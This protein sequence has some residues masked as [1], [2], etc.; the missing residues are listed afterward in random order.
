MKTITEGN[1]T[2]FDFENPTQK[3]RDWLKNNFNIQKEKIEHINEYLFL[4][5]RAPIFRQEKKT[6]QSVGLDIFINENRLITVHNEAIE[7]LKNFF[8]KCEKNP[9]LKSKYFGQTTGHL[10]YWISEEILDFAERQLVHI[11]KN[12]NRVEDNMF[13]ETERKLIKEIS[14]IKRDILDFR[15]AVRPLSRIFNT[16]INRGMKFWP[17]KSEDLKI[18]F[19]DLVGDY[20][21]IWSEIDNYADTINALEDTHANLLSNKTNNI[22]KTFTILSFITFPAI[23]V[24]DILAANAAAVYTIVGV[25]LITAAFTWIYFKTNKWL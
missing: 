11:G 1:L 4:E 19:N 5:M 13:K 7:P 16:L 18:Y 22:I 9:E 21:R 15:I 20:E 25:V 6:T 17:E 12:I 3:D 14:F 10:F 2:W 8:K 24:S 23:L